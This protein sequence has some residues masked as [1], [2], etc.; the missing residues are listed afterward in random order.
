MDL[1]DHSDSLGRKEHCAALRRTDLSGALEDGC[2]G[3]PD[4]LSADNVSG[5]IHLCIHKAPLLQ[6]DVVIQVGFDGGTFLGHNLGFDGGDLLHRHGL[7]QGS[8]HR[9]G[10]W[11]IPIAHKQTD[12]LTLLYLIWSVCTMPSL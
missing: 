2:S 8:E 1:K 7:R 11:I 4:P 10:G 12:K 3:P 9:R 6:G 5:D